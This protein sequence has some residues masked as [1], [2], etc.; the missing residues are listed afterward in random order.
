VIPEAKRKRMDAIST[1]AGIIAAIAMDQRRSLRRMIANAAGAAED[2]ISD[3]QLVEFK[4]AVCESLSP[5]ASA[6]LLDPEYGMAAA[7]HKAEACGLLLTYEADGYENPR[8]HRMLALL[9]RM[10]VARLAALGASAA[11][12]LLSW[13][14]DDV[15]GANDEKRALLERI[16][17]ECAAQD[18]PFLLEPVVYDPASSDIVHRKPELVV[19]TIEEFSRPVYKVDVLKVEFPVLASSVGPVFSQQ[20]AFDWYR[21][22]DAAA[23]LPYI[24]LSAGVS[25]AEFIG[26]LELAAKAGARFSGVLCGR[27]A[28]QDG[29][30]EFARGGVPAFTQWLASEG[31]RNVQRI[32]DCLQSAA[33]WHER[34]GGPR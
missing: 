16:G 32:V 29:I 9:P 20:Q 31:A 11:K 30:P 12:I 6:I 33:P 21:A 27:A 10:S 15:D 8:P 34:L 13:A 18:L 3:T 14:P 7:S 19:R 22:A 24:Y 17:S 28:W 23:R 25:I 1:P 2:A 4:T 5:H 26:S